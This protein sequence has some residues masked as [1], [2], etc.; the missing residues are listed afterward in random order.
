[1]VIIVTGGTHT[2]KTRLSQR[3][4]EK[5]GMPYFS[6]DHIKMGLI[7]SGYCDLTPEV[8]DEELTDYLWPV[9]REMI[10][11][12]IENRQNFIVEG[13]YVPFTWRGDFDEE[14]LREIRFICLCFSEKYIDGHYDDILSYAN[15]IENRI[16]EDYLTRDLLKLS[17]IH[18]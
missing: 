17:L 5:L 12:A 1:M 18:I 13:C 3:L 8:P 10:K 6:M 7:R 2:G 16:E 4:M 15:C 11:T 9:V 14:Y